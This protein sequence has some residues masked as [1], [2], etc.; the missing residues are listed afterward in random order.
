MS[1][2]PSDSPFRIPYDQLC[3]LVAAALRAH[4][5]P[6]ALASTE[7]AIM[8]EADLHGTPSHGVKMLPAL[9]RALDSGL[10]SADPQI[11]TVTDFGAIC[12]V[13]GDNGIGRHVALTAMQTA[14]QRARQFGVGV[15]L[16]K[17]T[18]HWGRAHAYA[19]RA[20]QAGCIGFCTTNAVRSMAAWGA[21]KP[22]IGNNP[23]AIG[24][25]R[26]D[27]EPM[28]LDIA[29][30]QA[31]VGKVTT[32]L[33]EG[34]PLPAGWGVDASGKPSSDPQAILSG[35]VSP[36]GGHKGSGLALMME[37]MTA[38]LGGGDF[39]DDIVVPPGGIETNASKIF[40]A[41]NV[42]A[43]GAAA[44]FAPRIDAFIDYLRAE[45]ADTEPFLYPGERGWQDSARNLRE[46]VPLH[47]EIVVLL[48]QAG[49]KL[50]G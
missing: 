18:T 1:S 17:R 48:E 25:P 22:V 9:L 19:L 44:D 7:A 35:A 26:G 10:A 46:G 16:A 27:A 42:E 38:A 13:D 39:C 24:V 40:I 4:G 12:V 20:A 11:R 14:V 32:W 34:R 41:L 3:A 5:V 6:E 49:V 50:R 47:E 8:A 36:M 2:V 23:I 29:M 33:R 45:A 31:A 28:V 30:S 15:C 37:M 43:F 21:T